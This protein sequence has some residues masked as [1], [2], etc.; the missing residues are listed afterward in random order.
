LVTFCP[1]IFQ[2]STAILVSAGAPNP[3]LDLSGEE[4]TLPGKGINAQLNSKDSNRLL[5]YLT[6]HT[7]MA[8]E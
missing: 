1:E 4:N 8:A 7:D 6:R 2:C 3:N 5:M